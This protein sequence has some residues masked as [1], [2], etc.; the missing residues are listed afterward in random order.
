MLQVHVQPNAKRNE[1]AGLHGAEL[2]VRLHAPPVDG[3]ANA[4]LI[5]FL[6]ER[7]GVPRSAVEI[8]RGESGRSKQVLVR[9]KSL[10]ELAALNL[11]ASR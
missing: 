3:K 8:L 9:G 5:E 1:I 4:E 11:D 10:A 6:S 2:K 7:L